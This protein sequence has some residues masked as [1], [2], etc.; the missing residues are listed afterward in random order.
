MGNMGRLAGSPIETPVAELPS[1]NEGNKKEPAS[2][3]TQRHSAK[4]AKPQTLIPKP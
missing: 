3:S 4:T 2:S 1:Y